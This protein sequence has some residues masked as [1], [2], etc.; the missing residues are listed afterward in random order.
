MREHR[1]WW[2]SFLRAYIVLPYQSG[3]PGEE[4]EESDQQETVEDEKEENAR[5]DLHHLSGGG[6]FDLSEVL[7][8]QLLT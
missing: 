6:E 7:L 8:P 1:I 5:D 3:I 4:G 2:E